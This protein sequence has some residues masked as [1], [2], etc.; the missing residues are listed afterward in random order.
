[1]SISEFDDEGT[2]LNLDQDC[3]I[4]D[5]YSTT[6]EGNEIKESFEPENAGKIDETKEPKVTETLKKSENFDKPLGETEKT[7]E[8]IENKAIFVCQ[9]CDKTLSCLGNLNKHVKEVHNKE[10]KV[11][12]YNCTACDSKF[13]FKKYLAKHINTVHKEKKKVHPGIKCKICNS[14]FTTKLS[15]KG[16][17]RAF[18]HKERSFQCSRCDKAFSYEPNMIHHIQVVH[19]GKRPFH[20]EFC[21]KN[22][23][24]R[25]NLKSH[26]A[27]VHEAGLDI[28]I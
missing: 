10:K 17:I 22:F 12:V 26:I 5:D 11:K 27:S 7:D 28:S 19:E 16:H 1:M 24:T 4:I 3:V 2:I 23:A 9:L 18:H 25:Q 20:C 15:L 6:L 14:T 21:I 8:N 13:S